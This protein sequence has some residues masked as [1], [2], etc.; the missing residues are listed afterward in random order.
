MVK[1]YLSNN[2]FDNSPKIEFVPWKISV[3][4]K[5][6]DPTRKPLVFL[7]LGKKYYR[8][9]VT[10]DYNAAQKTKK[11]LAFFN[12]D[13]WENE[14]MDQ[15][16]WDY[17][18]KAPIL[19]N[20]KCLVSGD[21]QNKNQLF[22]YIEE[23]NEKHRKL[24]RKKSG[25]VAALKDSVMDKLFSRSVDIADPYGLCDSG[26]IA[27]IL[28]ISKYMASKI[29]N[30]L[31]RCGYVRYCHE[32]GVSTWTGN[33]FCMHGYVRTPEAEQ[34]QYRSVFCKVA[35]REAKYWA[36]NLGGLPI[37]YWKLFTKN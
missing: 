26:W 3:W 4:K 32:G 34:S 29:L 13:R 37:D 14:V 6:K 22:S 19:N 1:R 17:M 27:E 18:D 30:D 9:P 7:E 31:N 28:N 10:S 24:T 11:I 15:Y 23:Q 8:I 2:I 12:K 20:W 33:V 25:D 16:V 35:W 21:E 36:E 5:K